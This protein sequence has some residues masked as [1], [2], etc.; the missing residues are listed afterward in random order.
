MQYIFPPGIIQEN[1]VL[2]YMDEIVTSISV[3]IS[4]SK[5][6]LTELGDEKELHPIAPD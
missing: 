5:I 2:L 6:T 1:A 3:M 4:G